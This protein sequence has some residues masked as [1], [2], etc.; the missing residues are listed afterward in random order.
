MGNMMMMMT[1]PYASVCRSA[2][3]GSEA[4]EL[5]CCASVRTIAVFCFLLG[6][7]ALG[8]WRLCTIICVAAFLSC[9]QCYALL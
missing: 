9:G 4:C 3:V 7:A 6:A 5:L 2:V 8:V 1:L